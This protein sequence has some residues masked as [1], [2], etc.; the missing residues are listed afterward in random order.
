MKRDNNVIRIT[1]TETGE[2]RYFTKDTYVQIYIRCSQAAMPLI[3]AGK[4]RS[5]ANYKYE[6]VDG[7]ELKYKDINIL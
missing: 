1:N 3:K 7:G 2:V 6:I 5:Y 4:S